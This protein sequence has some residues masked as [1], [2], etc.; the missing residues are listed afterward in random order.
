MKLECLV[1]KLECLAKCSAGAT[2]KSHV[3]RLE[4][5]G[6][7]VNG[8]VLKLPENHYVNVI[9]ADRVRKRHEREKNRSSTS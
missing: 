8:V 5:L 3:D 4:Y 1:L 9:E 7:K 2:I 6:T